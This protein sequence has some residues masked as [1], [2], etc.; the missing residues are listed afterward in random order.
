MVEVNR[1]INDSKFW[2]FK[3]LGATCF[4]AYNNGDINNNTLAGQ[5]VISNSRTSWQE[6]K[7]DGWADRSAERHD[8]QAGGQ[9]DRQ[10][11][12]TSQPVQYIL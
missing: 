12:H 7:T 8:R 6:S 10:G 5:Q 11:H 9:K 4:V 1:K 2:R 3:C